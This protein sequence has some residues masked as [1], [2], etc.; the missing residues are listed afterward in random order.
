MAEPKK[1]FEPNHFFYA[2]IRVVLYSLYWTFFRF[3]YEGS[4]RVPPASDRRGVILAPNHTSYLDPPILGISLPRRVT[5]LAKDY[6]FRAFFVGWVLRM[7]GALPIKAGAK[8]RDLKS[9]RDLLRILADGR[10]VVVFPEGTRSADGEF[11]DPES[12]IGFLALKSK[13]WVVP[14]YIEGAFKAFPKGAKFFK[15]S[16]VRVSYGEAFIPADD[17]SLSQAQDPYMAVSRRIMVDIKKLKDARVQS[18]Q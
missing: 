2:L 9:I 14:V 17:V 11:K 1:E 12:G 6:L 5:Y 18:R 15:C 16:P 3:K 4:E 10:C 13:S 7:I 8:D